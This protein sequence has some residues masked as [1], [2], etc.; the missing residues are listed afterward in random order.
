MD[1]NNS[2]STNVLSNSMAMP[3]YPMPQYYPENIQVK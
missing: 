3:P 2:A 1:F